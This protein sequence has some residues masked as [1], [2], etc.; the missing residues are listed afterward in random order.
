M[1]AVDDVALAMIQGPKVEPLPLALVALAHLVILTN[2]STAT[3]DLSDVGVAALT[4]Y[5][6]LRVDWFT[7]ANR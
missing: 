3:E 2:G 1:P 4:D 5:V 7:L 6:A